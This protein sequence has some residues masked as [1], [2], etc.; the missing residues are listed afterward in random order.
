MKED[1]AG[2]WFQHQTGDQVS[3]NYREI[4]QGIYDQNAELAVK[5]TVFKQRH[6]GRYCVDDDKRT[7]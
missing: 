3:H 1:S 7:A 5:K 2:T 6:S 4:V